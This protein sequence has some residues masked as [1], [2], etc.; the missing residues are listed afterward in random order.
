MKI[1]RRCGNI[2]EDTDRFCMRCGTCLGDP[3]HNGNML[4]RYLFISADDIRFLGCAKEIN[5]STRKTDK[6]RLP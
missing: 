2:A 4:Y 6:R 3:D 1:C 5:G